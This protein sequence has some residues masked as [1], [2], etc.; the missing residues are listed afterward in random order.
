[1]DLETLRQLA[2]Q[3]LWAASGISLLAG[4]F[5]SL[6]PLAIAALPVPL[7]YVTHARAPK[8]AARFG[9]SF[10]AGMIGAHAVLGLVAS[11]GGQAVQVLLGHY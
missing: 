1:M 9:L 10:I 11:F 3:S 2:S 7:A 4:L 5:F 6:S 8:E